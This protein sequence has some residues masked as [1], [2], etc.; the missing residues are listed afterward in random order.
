[1]G[2]G[3]RRKRKGL[4]IREETSGWVDELD[5]WASILNQPSGA[6]YLPVVEATLAADRAG[7][8]PVRR[9]IPPVAAQAFV[10]LAESVTFQYRVRMDSNGFAVVEMASESRD[11]RVT[12]LGQF[13]ELFIENPARARLK[14]CG[15]CRKWFADRTRNASALRCSR[16]CTVK[17]SATE[18]TQR[19]RIARELE[20]V[21]KPPRDEKGG[22]R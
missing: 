2:R 11:P 14:R 17:W 20:S 19:R 21:R 5:V 12:G 4:A 7:G 6:A 15:L 13:V 1:M 22:A 3:R 8:Y 9:A 16:E 18:L 10:V